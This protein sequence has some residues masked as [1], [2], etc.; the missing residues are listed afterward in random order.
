[1][2]HSALQGITIA[3]GVVEMNKVIQPYYCRAMSESCERLCQ[4]ILDPI[5]CRDW[6]GSVDDC[7][8]D[9]DE[10]CEIIKFLAAC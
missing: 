3:S 9:R 7:V 5:R 8:L 6:Y 10:I 1:M 4:F 2:I